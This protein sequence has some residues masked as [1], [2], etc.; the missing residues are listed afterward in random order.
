[1]VVTGS[2]EARRM[3][4]RGS[5]GISDRVLEKGVVVLM[6]QFN[7]TSI[8]KVKV[9]MMNPQLMA[10]AESQAMSVVACPR[11]KVLGIEPLSWARKGDKL[12]F[13]RSNVRECSLAIAEG[14]IKGYLKHYAVSK[15][16]PKGAC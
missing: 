5:F 13:L 6:A 4:V 10:S 12:I 3:M 7:V 8:S 9:Q 14:I 1:M 2:L 15:N 11:L 16:G